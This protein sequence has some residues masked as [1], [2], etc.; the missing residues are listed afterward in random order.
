[1]QLFRCKCICR[2][3]WSGRKQHQAYVCKHVNNTHTCVIAFSICSYLR[4]GGC[5]VVC[6]LGLLVCPSVSGIVHWWNKKNSWFSFR[7][8]SDPHP[9]LGICFHFFCTTTS[10]VIDWKIVSKMTYNVSTGTLKP[11]A[12]Y[13]T[14][15]FSLS[16]NILKMPCL[17]A[18]ELIAIGN[19]AV[20][21]HVYWWEKPRW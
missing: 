14:V 16:C 2:C 21:G 18:V 9:D 13:Y 15:L 1:M 20:M 12:P 3:V 7:G 4:Q 19:P 11:A 6:C 5:V 8:H 10:Q 17:C